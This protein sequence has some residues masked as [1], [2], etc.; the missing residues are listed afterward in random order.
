MTK[1][2]INGVLSKI[3]FN[4]NDQYGKVKIGEFPVDVKVALLDGYSAGDEVEAT[5]SLGTY[6]GKTPTG[7][8]YTKITLNLLSVK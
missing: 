6:T 5:V 3:T 2:I 7:A 4:K 1:V 8:N